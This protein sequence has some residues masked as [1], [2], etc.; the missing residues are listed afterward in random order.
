MS[1][2]DTLNALEDEGRLV[3]YLPPEG[4]PLM[5]GLYLTTRFYRELADARTSVHVFGQMPAIRILFNRWV[6]GQVFV[7][8]LAGSRP[9]ADLARLQPP[10]DDIWE[11]RL[12]QHAPQLRIFT[13]F[14]APDVVVATNAVNRDTLGNA[15]ARAGK[16]SKA[17]VEA[18]YDCETEWKRLFG[19]AKP[20]RAD[21]IAGYVSKNYL[22]SE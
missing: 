21:R 20:Y 5:R 22:G 19:G 14:A 6:A 16:K 2:Y 12:T 13:R 15:S 8:R 10:P 1:I 11:F 17:W 7:M 4:I 18:M 9:D 3:R